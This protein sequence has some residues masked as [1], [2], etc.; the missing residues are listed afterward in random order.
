MTMYT[1]KSKY[2]I[3]PLIA[4]ICV[5]YLQ[6]GRDI[7]IYNSS[8]FSVG[9]YNEAH[10]KVLAN[11]L[12]I[13]DKKKCAEEILRKCKDNSFSS[14]DFCFDVYIPNE[15]YVDVYLSKFQAEKGNVNFSF[16]YLPKNRDEEWN[17]IDDSDK[18][19]L[20]IE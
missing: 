19:V 4:I 11:M 10:I 12:Y 2:V 9:T 1:N 13:S 5:V 15:L 8:I 7:D 20:E 6:Y 18:Y 17:F 3:I 14:V 16:S